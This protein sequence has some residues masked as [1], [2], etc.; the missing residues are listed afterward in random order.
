M[1]RWKRIFYYLMLNV[2]VSA[3]T[4]LAVLVIWEQSQSPA[5]N[6]NQLTRL[7]RGLANRP[8]AGQATAAPVAANPTGESPAATSGPPATPTPIYITYVSK[9]GDTL[10][11]IA[12]MYRI[13]VERLMAENGFMENVPL[14]VGEQL[15]IP[16]EEAGNEPAS[17]A[18]SGSSAAA[19]RLVIESVAGLGDLASERVRLVY[20]GDRELSLAGWQ[21]EDEDGNVFLFPQLTI[22]QQG[23]VLVWSRASANNAVELFWGLSQPVWESGETVT[24]RDAQGEEHATYAIP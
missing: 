16:I 19:G 22:Y 17:G 2:L 12:Q 23:A 10:D 18:T 7:F 1:Q 6:Q 15:R 8:E 4:V 21:L 20:E 14:G 13:S 11:S 5:A 9:D 24:L 3:C